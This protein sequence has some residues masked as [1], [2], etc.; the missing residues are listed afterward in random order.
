MHR[1][2]VRPSLT[3]IALRATPGLPS[4]P[5]HCIKSI[6]I[7]LYMNNHLIWKTCC[8]VVVMFKRPGLHADF[9]GAGGFLKKSLSV[10][11][12]KYRVSQQ[13]PY[14]DKPVFIHRIYIFTF[15]RIH[16]Q[17]RRPA[18]PAAGDKIKRPCH[19]GQK[20]YQYQ[21]IQGTKGFHLFKNNVLSPIRQ[22]FTSCLPTSE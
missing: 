16:H 10:L 18:S 20:N 3:L 13:P 7:R 21:K 5:R 12:H 6:F 9:I 15:R 22:Y 19:K 4:L 2:Y 8:P 17:K 11:N 14:T 1:R